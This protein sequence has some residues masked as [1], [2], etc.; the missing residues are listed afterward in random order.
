[1]NNF[2]DERIQSGDKIKF[3]HLKQPNVFKSHV[4][5]FPPQM[6]AEI[7]EE[8]CEYIDYERQWEGTFFSPVNAIMNVAGW[9]GEKINN[10]LDFCTGEAY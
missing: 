9:S 6:N 8:L 2:I 10:I 1:M 7:Y 4:I 3:C 5:S